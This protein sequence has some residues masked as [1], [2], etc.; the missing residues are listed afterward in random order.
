M[1]S[2]KDYTEFCEKNIFPALEELEERRKSISSKRYT[3]LLVVLILLVIQVIFYLLGTIPW[4]TIFISMFVVPFLFA[5]IYNRL[6]QDD[7]IADE[8]QD[9]VIKL[10]AKFLLEK[11]A[12]DEKLFIDYETHFSNSRLFMLLPEHYSGKNQA[13]G[14]LGNYPALFS[15]I[16]SGYHAVG[17]DGK[18]EWQSIFKGLFLITAFEKDLG[19][20][21]VVIPSELENNL[22]LIGKQIQKYHFQRGQSVPFLDDKEFSKHYVVYSEKPLETTKVLSPLVRSILLDF[23][24]KTGLQVYLAFMGSKIY[25]AFHGASLMNID[26]KKT[27]LDFEQ[28]QNFYLCLALVEVVL[29]DFNKRFI[30]KKGVDWSI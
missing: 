11:A 7:G 3:L 27:L 23:S 10:S 22:Y 5:F 14:L 13:K 30:T 20:Q 17:E 6:F 28:I 24:Q 1:K 21:S 9:I 8:V 19:I 26:L 12:F 16:D 2:P 15:E 4:W 25:F 29:D 18:S